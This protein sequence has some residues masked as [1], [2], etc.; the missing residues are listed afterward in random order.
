[1]RKGEGG[2][3]GCSTAVDPPPHLSMFF[4]DKIGQHTTTPHTHV[5]SRVPGGNLIRNNTPRRD[6]AKEVGPM[7]LSSKQIANF[8]A[9]KL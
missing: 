2:T 1:M 7:M 5:K 4:M 3:H 8:I 9:I 6:G